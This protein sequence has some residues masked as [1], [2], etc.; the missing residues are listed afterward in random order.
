MGIAEL[1]LIAAGLSMDALAVSLCK[2]L[3]MKKLKLS[4]ASV[5]ALFFGGFQMLMP[6]IG[7][8]IGSRFEKYITEYDHWV[9]FFLLLIIGGKMI[10]DAVRE[11]DDG[12]D[13]PYRLD[14]KELFVLAIATSID[15][16]AVGVAF[17][18]MQVH[19]LS[20]ALVIGVTTFTLSLAGVFVGH[21]FGAK[22]KSKAALVGGAVLILIG[23]KILLEDFG[24]I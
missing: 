5:I 14:I 17:A 22:Y 10:I 13:E 23:V 6:V 7:W 9:A 24:L 3:A 2:G 8:F 4:H 1:L 12:K 16:L 18:A 20:S 11:K 15:A 19:I 21:K